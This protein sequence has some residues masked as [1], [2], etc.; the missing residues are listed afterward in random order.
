M[1]YDLTENRSELDALRYRLRNSSG[2]GEADHAEMVG[3][4]LALDNVVF[5]TCPEGDNGWA[6]VADEMTL[7]RASG[8]GLARGAKLKF[9]K[10]AVAVPAG[11]QLSD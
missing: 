3:Q 4:Q 9:K 2:R 5:T 6:L 11:G 10:P 8:R 7:D 1:A